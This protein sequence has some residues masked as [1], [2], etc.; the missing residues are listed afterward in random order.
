LLIVHR[1]TF[2][3]SVNTIQVDGKVI[4]RVG[5]A[6]NGFIP[7]QQ[8]Y[9]PLLLKGLMVGLSLLLRVMPTYP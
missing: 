8:Y 7:P 2:V 5:P 1:Y 9:L 4:Q 3:S 6:V